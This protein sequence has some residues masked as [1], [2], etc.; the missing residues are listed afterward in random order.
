MAQDF[1]GSNNINL[2][3]PSGQFGTRLAGGHDAAS[4]RYIFTYL[5]PVT[6]YLFPEDDD[7]LLEYLE[8]D[9][10]MIEPKYFCPVI[11][12]LLVNGS[13]GIGTGWSTFIPQH[14]PLS[15]LD[16]IRGKLEKR[17]NLP[18]IEPYSRGF[19]GTIERLA[20]GSRYVSY[21]RAKKIDNTTVLID[22]LPIGIW[23]NAYKLRLL[24]MRDNGLIID[25]LEDHTT[26][27][28]SFTVKLKAVQLARLQQAG[29]E[30]A[31]KL[32]SSL[33]LTNMHAF[34]DKNT[35]LKFDSAESIADAF[36]PTRL[37]L[38]HDRKSVLLSKM[39]YETAL[40]RNKARF[41]KA[42]ANGEVDLISGRSTREETANSLRTLGFS[43]STDLEFIRKN[44]SMSLNLPTDLILRD[45]NPSV[46]QDHSD[47]DYLLRMPLSSL[48]VERI[49]GLHLEADKT[50]QALKDV[51][52]MTPED[53][54]MSDLEKLAPHLDSL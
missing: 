44:N 35:I 15:V 34:D 12:L 22:E 21:G 47:F 37:A 14:N 33:L 53:L 13:Q 3:V 36:F 20:D 26:T 40:L 19:H 38:Y 50:E 9:G 23:T 7:M 45:N 24:K 29:L 54:W 10:Q 41:I 52:R 51:E 30:K 16:Y 31:F 11:P 49:D 1:V 42:V 32:S 25:F 2:L 18:L 48:N 4:S 39:K 27:T 28:V 5:S 17:Q 6:R 46:T 43:S 8:D